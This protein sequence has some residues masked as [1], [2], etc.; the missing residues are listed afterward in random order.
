MPWQRDRLDQ[1]IRLDVQHR[2][3]CAPDEMDALVLGTSSAHQSKLQ[4]A[5]F[6]DAAGTPNAWRIILGCE[7]ELVILGGHPVPGSYFIC[8]ACPN[9]KSIA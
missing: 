7:H 6:I 1:I 2:G 3:D 9:H 4:M 5:V 8:N